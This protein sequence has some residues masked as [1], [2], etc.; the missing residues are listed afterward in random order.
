[1]DGADVLVGGRGE[2]TLAGGDGDDRL[3]GG[4]GEDDLSGGEG[5]DR[6]AGGNGDDSLSGG[7]GADRLNGGN[8][9]DSL[10]GGD[11]DDTLIGGRGNDEIDL[12]AGDDRAFGGSGD[13]TF[14]SGDGGNEIRGGSGT[15]TVSYENS[16][17]PVVADLSSRATA[18]STPGFTASF[19]DVDGSISNLS[20]IDFDAEPTHHEVVN[21]INYANSSS[22][23]FYEGGALDTFGAKFEGSIKITEGGTYTF[24]TGS[25]DGSSVWI[26]GE[27]VV[28]ND[29]LHS[30]RTESGSIELEP[31][32]YSIEVRYFEN[33]GIQGL[34]LE[35][36]GPDTGD[37][38]G[39]VTG[40][41][42]SVGAETDSF[43]SVE[44]LIGS[45]HGDV[46]TG[47]A[48]DNEIT[49]GAGD[50]MIDGGDGND[51]AVV[52]GAF[53]DAGFS[54][55]DA[56]RLVVETQDGSDTIENIETLRFEDQSVSVADIIE[57][58][59]AEAVVGGD[60]D[61]LIV[62]D[63]QANSIDGAGGADRI[64]G[65][66][67]DDDI[68]GGAGDDFIV[69][70]EGSDAIDGG[71][72][73]DTVSYANSETGVAVDLEAGQTGQSSPGFTATFF[74]VG[75]TIRNLSDVD[76]DAEPA[77][78]EVVSDINYSNSGGTSFYEGAP[79]DR[80]A[81]K[82]EGEINITEGGTYTFRTG[83]DDGSSV[84]INGER[85]VGNDGLHSYRNQSGEIELE[86]GE[87][88]IEVRY[89][90]NTGSQGVRLDYSGPD[91]DGEMTLVNEDVV[92]T[93]GDV[94]TLENVENVVGSEFDDVLKG[95]A[96][97]NTLSGGAGDDVMSGGDGDDAF[98]V[99]VNG[100]SDSID[101][102]AG[103]GWTDMI[104]LDDVGGARVASDATSFDAG[105]WTLSLSSGSIT[106]ETDASLTFTDDAAGSIEFANGDTVD[107][108]NVEAISWS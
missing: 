48:A 2:D 71:E 99:E 13:D 85:V 5:A 24:Q 100:G 32:E 9:D 12:G 11:G 59:T 40:D 91:T 78:Q 28:G 45:D 16:D 3:N 10:S 46:L 75:T 72:G 92:N 90:E 60:G 106:S 50:D 68:D 51:T 49:G 77:H 105:D 22:T 42:V 94:D 18:T 4:A 108:T 96:G 41:V 37:V 64:F 20:Q 83:S 82:F 66:A 7:D 73:V 87:H 74:D 43:H 27:R 81:A 39:L 80:F 70:G 58:T 88:T 63:A 76:F 57:V 89:F 56:G 69:G 17:G 52:G 44:N 29:G 54:I 19:F 103:V 35:Y 97:D 34:S 23:E 25:D 1:G 8:G 47:N 67:G 55:D 79:L 30:Y 14:F 65:G 93:G 31:G 95:D 26:N 98:I 61:E 101:G 6:L 53:E 86:P 38:M 33:T 104:V 36:S 107:F 21:E 84:W 102:G 15:D 62:G